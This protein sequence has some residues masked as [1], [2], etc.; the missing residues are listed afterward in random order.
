MQ[1]NE[2][3]FDNDPHH[4]IIAK[5]IT[6]AIPIDIGGKPFITGSNERIFKGE[7]EII[8]TIGIKNILKNNYV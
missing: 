3:Y 1:R 8:V 4:R 2:L 7:I 5:V 6:I